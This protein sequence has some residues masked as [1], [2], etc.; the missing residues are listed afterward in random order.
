[1]GKEGPKDRLEMVSRE[2]PWAKPSHSWNLRCRK[3]CSRC[4]ALSI[5]K[6]KPADR[7]LLSQPVPAQLL[8]LWRP[9]QR[10]PWQALCAGPSPWSAA[11]RLEDDM[12]GHK[13]PI[14]VLVRVRGRPYWL[15]KMAV[16]YRSS[17][18]I[19]TRTVLT[20]RSFSRIHPLVRAREGVR[21]FGLYNTVVAMLAQTVR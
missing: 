19:F 14:R 6:S 20:S 3:I 21:Y 10:H 15:N 13:F 2:P 5:C 1:M 8:E 11:G 9:W 4:G 16:N 7:M 12:S 17:I 18:Q